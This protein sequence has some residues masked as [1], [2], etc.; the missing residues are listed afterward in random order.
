MGNR[1]LACLVGGPKLEGDAVMF[2]KECLSWSYG[3]CY[4][5]ELET[6]GEHPT[7]WVSDWLV[8]SS[9]DLLRRFP[10]QSPDR[11][12]SL[13]SPYRVPPGKT[14]SSSFR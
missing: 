1:R 8:E 9:D 4:S 3:Y 10:C 7:C 2:C 13:D 11:L 5:Q 14:E 12:R 6:D